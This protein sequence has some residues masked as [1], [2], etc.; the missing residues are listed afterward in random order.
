MV[1]WG[2][3]L[4]KGRSV[5]TPLAADEPDGSLLSFIFHEGA[6]RTRTSYIS[7]S[8]IICYRYQISQQSI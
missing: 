3:V 8:C 5:V 2:C 4:H 1:T 6:T 7:Y